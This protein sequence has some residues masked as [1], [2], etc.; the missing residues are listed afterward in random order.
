ML[1]SARFIIRIKAEIPLH[2]LGREYFFKKRFVIFHIFC[3]FAS[4]S[5]SFLSQL[6]V[7][8]D[9]SGFF[10]ALTKVQLS[11]DFTSSFCDYFLISDFPRESFQRT[12]AFIHFPDTPCAASTTAASTGSVQ[13]L[14]LAITCHQLLKH[15]IRAVRPILA[16]ASLSVPYV[17]AVSPSGEG[18]VRATIKVFRYFRIP[19]HVYFGRD[20]AINQSGIVDVS[21]HRDVSVG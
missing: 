12:L 1:D 10:Y 21:L 15:F 8:G 6:L 16:H 19:I 9:E 5:R 20:I 2:P 4:Q 7:T 17:A 13:N 18:L 11:T 3:T 14:N